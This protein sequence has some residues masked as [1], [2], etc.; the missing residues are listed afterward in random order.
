MFLQ[1]VEDSFMDSVEDSEL[2]LEYQQFQEFVVAEEHLL[3]DLA[4]G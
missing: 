4:A 2:T 1:N 3:T